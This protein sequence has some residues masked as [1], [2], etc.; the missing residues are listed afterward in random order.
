M[1]RNKFYLVFVVFM[2]VFGFTAD[3]NVLKLRPHKPTSFCAAK[4][5]QKDETHRRHIGF[6]AA[7]ER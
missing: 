7:V 4:V 5:K 2:I 6:F 3:S 1:L